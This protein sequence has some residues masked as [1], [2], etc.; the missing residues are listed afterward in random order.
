MLRLISLLFA[1]VV[2]SKSPIP[3]FLWSGER[4]FSLDHGETGDA[5]ET[6][7]LSNALKQLVRPSEQLSTKL[8]Q[9]ISLQAP[10]EVVVAFVASQWD[11][12]QFQQLPLQDLLQRSA[13]SLVAP[14]LYSEGKVS[15]VLVNALSSPRYRVIAAQLSGDR[16]KQNNLSGCDALMA[17]LH[18][19][20]RI[21]SDGVTQLVLTT[22][23]QYDSTTGDCMRRV[24]E[25]VR[26][27]TDR[28]VGLVSADNSKQIM[29]EFQE[30]EM[31]TRPGRRLLQQKFAATT[32]DTYTGP[33]YITSSILFGILLSFFLLFMLW[34]G[35]SCLMSIEGPVRFAYQH[36]THSLTKEY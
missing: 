19:N 31:A 24:S 11:A 10:P 26:T 9:H 33:Q 22:F 30:N 6:K 16:K 1:L 35:I 13:S 18:E 23:N 8:D 2:A 3:V 34:M 25:F 21:F 17:S 15:D 5:L 7:D 32:N 27:H 4:S 20:E 36:P 28:Y 14:Y 12:R 29:T